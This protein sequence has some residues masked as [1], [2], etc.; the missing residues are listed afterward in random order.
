MSRRVPTRREAL[1]HLL[2]V[3]AS[4]AAGGGCAALGLG[5]GGSLVAPVDRIPAGTA[6]RTT[7]GGRQLIVINTEGQLRAFSGL[8]THESCELGW[9]PRQQ[10]IRCPCHGSAFGPDGGV[11]AGPATEPLE[12]FPVMVKRGRLYLQEGS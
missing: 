6:L 10:L 9:N 11:R 12:E 8:C 3:G 2:C 4:I 1:G 7:V 5:G